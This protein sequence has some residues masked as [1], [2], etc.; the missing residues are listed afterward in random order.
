RDAEQ[1]P[2][3]RRRIARAHFFGSLVGYEIEVRGS[4]PK[5]QL[6]ERAALRPPVGEGHGRDGHLLIA[7]T[8][9]PQSDEPL[10]FAKRE[11]TKEDAM[12]HAEQGGVG[13]NAERE[14][15]HGD[16]GEAGILLQLPQTEMNIAPHG[17]SVDGLAGSLVQKKWR[18]ELVHSQS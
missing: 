5:R 10:L 3:T 2:E 15:E 13:A 4:G 11:R 14:G 8:A 18:R 12:D 6:L 17:V 9:L 7:G 1:R 16:D